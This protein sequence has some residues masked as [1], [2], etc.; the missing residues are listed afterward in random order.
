MGRARSNP[1]NQGPFHDSVLV[2]CSRVA[3]IRS[4]SCGK[5]EC[6][7]EMWVFG[8]YGRAASAW[9][10]AVGRTVWMSSQRPP[11]RTR[12]PS[13]VHRRYPAAVTVSEYVPGRSPAA[14]MTETGLSPGARPTTVSAN[15]P[16]TMM[17]VGREL[18]GPPVV[19]STTVTYNPKFPA[20]LH[21]ANGPM[22]PAQ[23]ARTEKYATRA[24]RVVRAT[25]A[26]RSC[27]LIRG[28]RRQQGEKGTE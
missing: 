9:R 4:C 24:A 27:G 3:G 5:N 28:C 18:G 26:E 21:G 13:R 7:Q 8:C 14:G 25:L 22:Q 17:S 19:E 23:R 2:S 11:S 1:I 12:T 15:V 6:D 10:R 20:P 16:S